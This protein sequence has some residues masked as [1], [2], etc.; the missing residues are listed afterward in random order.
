MVAREALRYN[1]YYFLSIRFL[2]FL[3]F[4][5]PLKLHRLGKCF[6]SGVCSLESD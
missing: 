6:N 2:F 5:L 4:E 1:E 3:K